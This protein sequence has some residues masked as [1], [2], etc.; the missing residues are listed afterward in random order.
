M[1]A[2]AIVEERDESLH[3]TQRLL[4]V[5]RCSIGELFKLLVY[6]FKLPIFLFHFSSSLLHLSFQLFCKQ[7]LISNILSDAN[8]VAGLLVPVIEHF[9]SYPYPSFTTL[10]KTYPCLI[11]QIA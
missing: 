3:L 8:Q 2:M 11:I 5:M 10:G 1:I 6:F 9:S 7:L 4:H